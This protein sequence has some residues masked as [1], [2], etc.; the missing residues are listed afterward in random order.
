V[1]GTVAIERDGRVLWSKAIAT[2]ESEMSHNLA[3][4]EHHHFKF[5]AHRRPGDVHVHFFGAV[6]LSFGAG[7][8]L[9]DGDTMVIHFAGFGRA[10]RNPVTVAAPSDAP[11]IVTPLG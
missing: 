7:V 5:D 4:L 6:S 8:R 10:L 1:P 3:N 9:A 2:G 11:V